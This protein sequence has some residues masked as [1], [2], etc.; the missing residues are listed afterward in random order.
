MQSGKK[1][2]SALFL[3]AFLILAA[4]SLAV[5]NQFGFPQVHHGWRPYMLYERS[6]THRQEGL[7]IRGT[8]PVISNTSM[9]SV[10]NAAPFI[11][12]YID[13]D[14]VAA[15]IAEARRLR[16][17]AITFS[18]EYHSTD[19]IISLVIFA[20]V[21]T[22]LPH[23]LVRSVNFCAHNGM[24][25]TMNEATGME[26][27]PIAERILA[28]K[29][30]A[31][32][33]RYYAALGSQIPEAF[34]I[35]RNRLVILFD[36]FRLSTRVSSYDTIELRLRNIRTVNLWRDEY[37]PDGP[38]GLKMIPLRRVLEGL[39][40]EVRW[41]YD[42]WNNRRVV[43]YRD[44][45]DLIELR[46]GDNEYIVHGTQR[47]SL[48]VAPQVFYNIFTGRP[49]TYVPITFFDQILP[50]TTYTIGWDDSITFIA[51]VN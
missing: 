18:F 41:E 13:D 6:L 27:T 31:N 49:H 42:R 39:G 4:P 51:Y 21:S 10:F 30:R 50:L 44:Y 22:T 23:T 38:Y 2:T 35:T 47:R 17:R 40:Y 24:I 9:H 46:I 16:A 33:E 11:N 29:I 3:I 20:D 5:A 28:E 43:I 34:Y 25:L 37:R 14:I 45:F 12:N 19:D 15:L 7:D 48:E 1:V 8:V 36:G 26:I 32:P